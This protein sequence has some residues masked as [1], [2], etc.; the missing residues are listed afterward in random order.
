MGC[1]TVCAR[2]CGRGDPCKDPASQSAWLKSIP[3]QLAGGWQPSCSRPLQSLLLLYLRLAFRV[4]LAVSCCR[5]CNC[6][7]LD[8]CFGCLH[9]A[10]VLRFIKACAVTRT[11]Q[12]GLLR[13]DLSTRGLSLCRCYPGQQCGAGDCGNSDGR[14]QR[15]SVHDRLRLSGCVD[16]IL[17]L[18]YRRDPESEK[19]RCAKRFIAHSSKSRVGA[20][21]R[22]DRKTRPLAKTYPPRGQTRSEEHGV[23]RVDYKG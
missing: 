20:G 23:C 8:S 14:F 15:D 16:R 4:G 21:N 13:L 6:L 10:R 17:G 18:K 2:G 12:F 5:T 7:S 22:S 9:I 3:V 1:D 19:P 11:Y